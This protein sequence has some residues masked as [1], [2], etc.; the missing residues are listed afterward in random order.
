MTQSPLHPIHPTHPTC[1]DQNMLIQWPTCWSS[2]FTQRQ[3]IP[4]DQD[5]RMDRLT[6]DVQIAHNQLITQSTSTTTS[7]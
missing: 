2:Q 6:L 4:T 3:A 7:N 5:A 1:Y